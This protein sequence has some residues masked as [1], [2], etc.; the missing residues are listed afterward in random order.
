MTEMRSS[1]THSDVTFPA[2]LHF[3]EHGHKTDD[4][5]CIR[6]K[7]KKWLGHGGGNVGKVAPRAGLFLHSSLENLVSLYRS[8]PT[9][10]TWHV[11]S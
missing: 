7:K 11:F 6:I 5:K 8:I 2:A 9:Q 1:I 4:F 3:S 10:S